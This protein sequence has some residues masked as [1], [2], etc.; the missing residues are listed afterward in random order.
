MTTAKKS[1]HWVIVYTGSDEADICDDSVFKSKR[2]A[3]KELNWWQGTLKDG[4]YVMVDMML[5]EEEADALRATPW[6]GD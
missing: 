5:T 1:K 2:L 6:K 4:R 3:S